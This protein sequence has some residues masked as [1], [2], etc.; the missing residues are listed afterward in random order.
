MVQILKSPKYREQRLELNIAG[1]VVMEEDDVLSEALERLYSYRGSW[2]KAQD[3]GYNIFK[4][5]NRKRNSISISQVKNQVRECLS[6]MI[7]RGAIQ[8]NVYSIVQINGSLL[9]IDITI[10]NELG[11]QFQAIFRSYLLV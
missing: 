8:D 11:K 6:P 2:F 10:T 1:Q 4:N 9:S 5:I 7:T 3:Y